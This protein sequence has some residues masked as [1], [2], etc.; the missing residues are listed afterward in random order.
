VWAV[1]LSCMKCP[2]FQFSVNFLKKVRELI[3]HSVRNL[4]FRQEKLSCY[5]PSTTCA[6]HSDFPIVYRHTAWITTVHWSEPPRDL[7]LVSWEEANSLPTSDFK[8]IG[9]MI[10]WNLWITSNSYLLNPFLNVERVDDV[11]YETGNSS[12][13]S[14]RR[15]FNLF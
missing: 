7:W 12:S 1:A 10:N 15:C 14:S 11:A 13:S 9:L 3:K 2:F 8:T 4:L 6:P 5:S